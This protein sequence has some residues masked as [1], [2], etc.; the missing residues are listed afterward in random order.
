MLKDCREFIDDSLHQ[1]V[2]FSLRTSTVPTVWK[3]DKIVPIFKSGNQKQAEI[4]D[5]FQSYQFYQNLL[6][7]QYTHNC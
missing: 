2:N 1:I 3:Q 4:I 5:Q 6:R 7:K